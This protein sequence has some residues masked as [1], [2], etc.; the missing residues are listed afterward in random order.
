MGK[1]I[2]SKEVFLKESIKNEPM[3]GE[4]ILEDLTDTHFIKDITG[5]SILIRDKDYEMLE[6]EHD[7]FSNTYN[8][9]L[10]VYD[11]K[12]KYHTYMENNY[13]KFSIF[14]NNY[15]KSNGYDSPVIMIGKSY[16]GD[17]NDKSMIFEMRKY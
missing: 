13:Q 17:D 5:K 4:Y 10:R 1:Y 3:G 9:R 7:S 16:Y 15:V 2:K 11:V 12:D 6:T 8:F 14:Y